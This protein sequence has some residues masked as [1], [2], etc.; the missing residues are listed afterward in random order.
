MPGDGGG[1]RRARAQG[2]DPEEG[3]GGFQR[4]PVREQRPRAGKHRLR[5]HERPRMDVLDRE[6]DAD[7][8]AGEQEDS[9]LALMAE[10]ELMRL[11]AAVHAG[12]GAEDGVADQLGTPGRQQHQGRHGHADRHPP[13]RDVVLV[14]RGQAVQR[15]DVAQQ[16]L[17][18]CLSAFFR[19]PG[20]DSGPDTP[21]ACS[22]SFPQRVSIR[23]RPHRAG[24]WLRSLDYRCRVGPGRLRPRPGLS[25]LR[26]AL[27]RSPRT[28]RPSACPCARGRSAGSRPASQPVRGPRP[29][30]PRSAWS[31]A[32]ASGRIP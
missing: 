14:G 25:R 5:D 28:M 20:T 22:G 17:H 2:Q 7:S 21:K 11:G 31:P 23:N 3:T 4:R 18:N 12:Q 24:L 13:R 27:R 8:H 32:A 9:C 15:T 19:V 30:C 26:R 16:G 1:N 6:E 10:P 29:G